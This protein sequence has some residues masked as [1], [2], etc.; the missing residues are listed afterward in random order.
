MLLIWLSHILDART[1]IYGGSRAFKVVSG[2]S[3][4]VGDSC[5]T[6]LLTLPSHT[7]THVDAPYHFIADGKTVDE[8]SP[9]TWIFKY[10]FISEMPV[11]P[12]QLLSAKDLN[13]NLEPNKEVDLLLIRTGFEELRNEEIY[14]K[15]GPGL[16]ADLVPLLLDCYP[17][18]R[19][20]GVDFISI[21][22]LKN[23]NEGRAVHKGFTEKGLLIFED[24]ALSGIGEGRSL[25]KVVALPLRF[26]NGDG[27]PCSII[28]WIANQ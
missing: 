14:W 15:E 6:S 13:Y 18:L 12:G 16:S 26:K 10:P 28:G 17:N 22:S 21:S 20:V 1:P 23:R 2:K 8:Y 27:A 9:E 11:N 3:T 19:A 5:N 25:E 4:A 7:G 24:M